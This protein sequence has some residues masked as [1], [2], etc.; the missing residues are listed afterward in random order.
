MG[1]LHACSSNARD[2]RP[3]QNGQIEGTKNSHSRTALKEWL[4]DTGATISV[5][6][7]SNAEQFDLTV[8]GGSASSTTGGG[9]ILLNSGLTRVFTLLK[10]TGADEQ[11]RCS[12]PIG[13]KSN[14]HGSEILG[15][16]QLAHVKAKVRWDPSRQDGDLFE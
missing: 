2:R 11:V 16:D 8:L 3:F 14:D 6:T 9:G 13:V 1:N 12:L 15:M 4:I 7:K 5:I 10:H